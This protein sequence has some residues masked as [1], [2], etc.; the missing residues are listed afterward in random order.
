MLIVCVGVA[1]SAFCPQLLRAEDRTTPASPPNADNKDTKPFIT[2]WTTEK[3]ENS[4]VRGN[5]LVEHVEQPVTQKL[6][7]ADPMLL[8][9][10]FVAIVRLDVSK[11]RRPFPT[12]RDEGILAMLKFGNSLPMGG[13]F[14]GELEKISKSFEE[15]IE[16]IPAERRPKDS[17]LA[18]FTSPDVNSGY[19]LVDSQLLRV[20]RDLNHR[21][22][23]V[24]ARTADEAA[25]R[26]ATLLTLLDLGVSRPVL[27]GSVP[28][29]P[30]PVHTV[31][32]A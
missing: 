32:T 27:L 24:R 8:E 10:Q 19:L 17:E 1:L 30:K 20:P 11:Y 13:R 14:P 22:Y 2:E 18:F 23:I 12:P 25:Q 16:R 26:A 15:Y 7:R 6:F 9:H 4:V 21:E 31:G 5:Y 3:I 28:K 29:G